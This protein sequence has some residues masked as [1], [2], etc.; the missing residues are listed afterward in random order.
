MWIPVLIVLG[1]MSGITLLLYGIDKIS[2][3]R[4][5]WRIPEKF[6]L[7][8]IVFGGS[9]GAVL[10]MLFFHHKCNF[11]RKWYFHVTIVLSALLHLAVLVMAMGLI[12][13]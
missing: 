7:T 9:V 3:M 8:A 5:A 13:L 11:R 4:G 10:G 1:I 2:A 12:T 6:L